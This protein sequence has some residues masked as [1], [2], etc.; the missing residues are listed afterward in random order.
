M[1]DEIMKIIALSVIIWAGIGFAIYIM[2]YVIVITSE[3]IREHINDK[4]EKNKK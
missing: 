4:K 2:I 1:T 3:D